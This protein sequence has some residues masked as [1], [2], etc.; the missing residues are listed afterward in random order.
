VKKYF[1][2]IFIALFSV[3]IAQDTKDLLELESMMD[4][5][6]A[7]DVEALDD[8]FEL[9]TDNMLDEL[10]ELAEG[11]DEAAEVEAEVD[12]ELMKEADEML[13]EL[14]RFPEF[15][16]AQI[17]QPAVDEILDILEATPPAEFDQDFKDDLEDVDLEDLD[18]DE[19]EKITV[20]QK[21]ITHAKGMDKKDHFDRMRRFKQYKSDLE[22]SDIQKSPIYTGSI[23]R[24]AKLY[25]ISESKVYKLPRDIY[26]NAHK[27]PDSDNYIYI[28]D[29]NLKLKYKV[30]YRDIVNID[31]IADLYIPPTYFEEKAPIVDKTRSQNIEEVP[32]AWRLRAHIDYL[33]SNFTADLVDSNEANSGMGLRVNGAYIFKWDLP[34]EIGLMGEY[35]EASF[36][37]SPSYA[38]MFNTSIGPVL[39][40]RPLDIGGKKVRISSAITTGISGNISYPSGGSIKRVNLQTNSFQIS[41]SQFVKNNWGEFILGLDFKRNWNKALADSATLS[42]DNNNRIDDSI[43]LFIGQEF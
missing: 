29:K 11:F 39:R 26:V 23:K 33:V 7:G 30:H 22:L 6:E 17:E 3:A 13:D 34:L 35:E 43:G 27:V 42:L 24:G 36:T 40:T 1:L 9:E 8:T 10:D 5:A 21:K 20:G 37:V 25:A 12:R 15:E 14:D 4:A 16:K 41:A 19:L 32:T 28:T 18:F 2:F 38:R 31:T